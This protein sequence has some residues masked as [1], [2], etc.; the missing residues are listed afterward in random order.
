MVK[1]DVDQSSSWTLK[2]RYK[3]GG[4]PTVIVTRADGTELD[5]V[6]GYP[7]E[8]DFLTWLAESGG[9]QPVDE[10]LARTDRSPAESSALALRLARDGRD[11]DALNVLADAEDGVD[12]RIARLTVAPTPEDAT[13]LAE[14][15]PERVLEWIFSVGEDLPT[16]TDEAIDQAIADALAVSKGFEAADLLYLQAS[17]SDDPRLYAA[18]AATLRSAMSG[19]PALDRAHYTFLASLYEHSGRPDLG[20]EVLQQAASVYP[21]EMTWYLAAAGLL[22]RQDEPQRALP[23]A[24]AASSLAYGDQLLRATRTHADVLWALGQEEEALALVD[25][26]LSDAEAPDDLQVRTHRYI[27]AL[28]TWREEHTTTEP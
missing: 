15:A 5:R 2:D 27:A 18:A 23:Y 4:Y 20:L 13:W 11:E 7:G 12:F 14:N 25:Q 17:R 9:I 3:V 19:D 21:H 6:V 26:V 1:I 8:A 22:L 24:I 16:E 10:L 28:Q